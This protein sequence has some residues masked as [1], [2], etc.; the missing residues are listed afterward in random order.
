MIRNAGPAKLARV[1]RLVVRVARRRNG[2]NRL[3]IPVAKGPAAPLYG[4]GGSLDSLALVHFIIEV[5]SELQKEFGLNLVLA[6]RHA[7]SRRESPFAT[8]GSLADYIVL[9]LESR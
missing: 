2:E 9:R 1:T 6:N 3:K 7:V 8:I 5:E 4:P